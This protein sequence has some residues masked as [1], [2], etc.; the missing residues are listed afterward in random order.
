MIFDSLYISLYTL[1]SIKISLWIKISI[2]IKKRY[3]YIKIR[4][5]MSLL[6]KF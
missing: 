2:S 1:Y 5:E 6:N 4:E 3:I